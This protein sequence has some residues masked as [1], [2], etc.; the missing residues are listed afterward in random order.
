[1]PFP[2]KTPLNVEI[3]PEAWNSMHNN[4]TRPFDRPRSG[5]IAVKVI[6]QL[7]DEVMKVFKA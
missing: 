2:E 5:R 6:N 7:G 4:T 3:N 1:L